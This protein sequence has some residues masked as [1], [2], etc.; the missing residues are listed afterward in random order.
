M[1]GT[2]GSKQWC[3]QSFPECGYGS[4]YYWA[5]F[6][7][8]VWQVLIKCCLFPTSIELYRTDINVDG[9]RHYEFFLS[10]VRHRVETEKDLIIFAKF[11]E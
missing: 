6:Q 2:F 5:P 10:F 7:Q 1:W 11:E 9:F 8:I 4:L 3:D